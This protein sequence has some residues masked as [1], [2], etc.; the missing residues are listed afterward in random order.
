MKLIEYTQKIVGLPYCAGGM[1]PRLGLGCFTI[2]YDWLKA[3]LPELPEEYHG[4]TLRNRRQR[5]DDDPDAA[6]AVM[7]QFFDEYLV[8][9][10]PAF[11]FT[12][13]VLW[14]SIVVKGKEFFA[15]SVHAGNGHM[16]GATPLRGVVLIP[17]RGYKVHRAWR[18]PGA[19]KEKG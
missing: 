7:L 2:V 13:D 18:I 4:Y 16:L 10:E 11:A 8:R 17:L 5:Y 6:N 9:I 1:D 12:G 3:H 19:R 14:S 15:A